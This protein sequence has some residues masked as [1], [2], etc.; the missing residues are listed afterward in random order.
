M[1]GQQTLVV[2]LN[3]Q[4]SVHKKPNFVLLLCMFRKFNFFLQQASKHV[5][6][7]KEIC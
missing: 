7:I 4:N 5:H 1:P 6:K 3:V 2:L